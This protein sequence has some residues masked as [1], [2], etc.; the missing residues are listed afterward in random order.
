MNIVF[1]SPGY[2][3]AISRFSVGPMITLQGH[4]TTKNYVNILTSQVHPMVQTLLTHGD[5]VFENDK[6][7]VHTSHIVQ[8]WFSEHEGD[9][10]HISWLPQ[11][12][13][14]NII[15]PLWSTLERKVRGCHLLL[16]SLS[17]LATVLREEWYKI[18]LAS[19]QKLYLCISRKTQAVL[20]AVSRH[21]IE[22]FRTLVNPCIW[23][24]RVGLDR[25]RR[26][27][28][29][30]PLVV[31]F[32]DSL[33]HE[34]SLKAWLRSD[35][36]PV[37]VSLEKDIPVNMELY[38]AV[39]MYWAV[40]MCCAGGAVSHVRLHSLQLYTIP[41]E[42]VTAVYRNL[43]STCAC[44]TRC[45]MRDCHVYTTRTNMKGVD[46]LI[47]VPPMPRYLLQPSNDTDT[48]MRSGNPGNLW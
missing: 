18:P 43:I 35:T 47:R 9:L 6:T 7:P 1:T 39:L 38:G 41:D 48:V 40:L 22:C 15:E 25:T 16:S 23:F 11:L 33:A 37:T 26:Y 2:C 27:V 28:Y 10:S 44:L 19:I 30:Q 4:I 17:E 46:C 5:R 21:C 14:L 13:D 32:N 36:D 8:N 45:V 34:R 29:R 3:D 31:G 12:P 20:K 24:Q 42:N